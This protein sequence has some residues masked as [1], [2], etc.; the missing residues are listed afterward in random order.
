MG[1]GC[2]S[3]P[4][5]TNIPPPTFRLHRADD[6]KR[7]EAI[8]QEDRRYQEDRR[9]LP[10]TEDRREGTAHQSD[11]TL[12]HLRPLQPQPPGQQQRSIG[13]SPGHP[14]GSCDTQQSSKK[15]RCSRL[16]PALAAQQALP[17]DF[18]LWTCTHVHPPPPPA[19]KDSPVPG[20]E[21]K[22]TWPGLQRGRLRKPASD[23]PHL[24]PL[25]PHTLFRTRQKAER[26]HRPDKGLLCSGPRG[27]NKHGPALARG[28]RTP[29][30]EPKQR[31]FDEP[32]RVREGNVART[33]TGYIE[34]G[35]NTPHVSQRLHPHKEGGSTLFYA[36]L[37]C[38]PLGPGNNAGAHSAVTV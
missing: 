6:T 25:E 22:Q 16:P 11:T 30:I 31:L 12:Q 35:G 33:T 17:L 21:E 9:H 4:R 32:G 18:A 2:G 26:P 28:Q 34:T 10:P 8:D 23:A 5:Q 24:S 38:V 19:T 13:E 1:Q 37:D 7:T 14:T 29:R 20:R 27:E 3:A 36:Q 15:L